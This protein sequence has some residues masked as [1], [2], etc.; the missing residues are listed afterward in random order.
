MQRYKRNRSK[1]SQAYLKNIYWDNT[2][3]IG[4]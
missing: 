4:L 2:L 1:A 3:I